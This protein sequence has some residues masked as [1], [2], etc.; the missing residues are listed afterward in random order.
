MALSKPI[1]AGLDCG[2]SN[3]RLKIVHGEEVLWESQSGPANWAS[4]PREV[5]TLNLKALFIGAPQ[6]DAIAGC[7]AGL[8]TQEDR[9][10]CTT[11][12]ATMSGA[13]YASSHPD[14]HAAWASCG[15]DRAIL[16]ISGTGAGILSRVNGNWVRSGGG[17]ALIDDCGSGS[18]AGRRFL[19]TVFRRHEGAAQVR[20]AI[21]E[22]LMI[23]NGPE[24]EFELMSH[25]Y[26]SSSPASALAA[27]ASDLLKHEIIEVVRLAEAEMA[28]YAEI[29][30]RHIEVFHSPSRSESCV[31]YRF[32][33]F[34]NAHPG[35][36]GSFEE[37]LGCATRTPELSALDAAIRLAMQTFEERTRS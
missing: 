31:V 30:R 33:G 1:L 36:V 27:L 23:T 26:R 32:G 6:P 8:L 4:T 37:R 5:L 24:F 35:L 3:A 10:E 28:E 34:W 2:G 9:A 17:G 20:S 18:S 22:I 7:F 15:D 16:A 14:S 25:V 19:Q 21:S 13:N 11:L 29:V 12:V